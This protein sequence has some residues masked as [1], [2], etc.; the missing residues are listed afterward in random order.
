MASPDGLLE[1]RCFSER[2]LDIFPRF[3][4]EYVFV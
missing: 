4:T 1:G 2:R 3:A